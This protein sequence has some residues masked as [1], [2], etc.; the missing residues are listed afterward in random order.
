MRYFVTQFPTVVDPHWSNADPA[1]F[2]I[3]GPDPGRIRFRIQSFDDPKIQHQKITAGKIF[4]RFFITNCNWLSQGLHKGLLATGE[5]FSPQMR[6]SMTSK[7]ENSLLFLYL[8]V[9]F[10]LLDPDPDP[11]TQIKADPC[12]SG[13]RSGSKTLQFPTSTCNFAH[14]FAKT[15]VAKSNHIRKKKIRYSNS[16]EDELCHGGSVQKTKKNLYFRAVMRIRIRDPV[17]FWPLDPGS[18][19]NNTDHISESLKNNFLG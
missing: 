15:K 18:G 14:C 17:P 3:A 11:T 9:I 2:L 13:Y 19:M 7:H 16:S 12:G 1:F 10:A 5:A 4:Y 6:T 8:W